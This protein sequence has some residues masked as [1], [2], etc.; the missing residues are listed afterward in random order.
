MPE[1]FLNKMV[2][3]SRFL[4]IHIYIPIVNASFEDQKRFQNNF[5]SQNWL[6]AVIEKFQK[7][8]LCFLWVHI[9][10]QRLLLLVHEC[11]RTLR[12]NNNGLHIEPSQK[13]AKRFI[14]VSENS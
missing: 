4:K 11:R 8:C 5:R 2:Y 12:G 9:C 3:A 14:I 6:K 7:R 1:K 10:I 13:Y